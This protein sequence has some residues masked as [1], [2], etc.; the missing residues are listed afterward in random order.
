MHA[1]SDGALPAPAVLAEDAERG[2][3]AAGVAGQRQTATHH[4]AAQR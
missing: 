4:A 2:A 1:V 3:A